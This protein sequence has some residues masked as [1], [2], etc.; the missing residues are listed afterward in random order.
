MPETR[1]DLQLPLVLRK[2]IHQLAARYNKWILAFAL[3]LC[4]SPLLLIALAALADAEYGQKLW[5]ELAA[6]W[7]WWLFLALLPVAVVFVWVTIRHERLTVTSMGLEYRSP[8]RGPLAFLRSLR[9][10][11]R[12]SWTEVQSAILRK[13]MPIPRT[14]ARRRRLVMKMRHGETR[15]L[16]PYAWYTVPDSAGL[17][18]REAINLKDERYL[19]AVHASPL[20]R[21]VAD[22]GLLEDAPEA[23]EESGDAGP[24]ADLPG[25]SFDMTSQPGMM[26]VLGGLVLTGGYAV[27]D[28]LFLSPW[29]YLEMPPVGPFLAAGVL[30][31]IVAMVVT[32]SAPI[33]E[34]STLAAL[35]ALAAAGAAYPGLLRVNAATDADGVSGYRYRQVAAGRFESVDHPG[36]PELVFSQGR[37][38]WEQFP[39]DAEREF[40]LARGE[41]AF[42]QL[43]LDEVRA[44]QRRFYRERRAARDDG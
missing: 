2:R 27:V 42:W 9:P 13:G 20:F 37:E 7:R 10:D 17:T 16:E 38:F 12:L 22:Q 43:D 28:G 21:I 15:S 6:D 3:L 5:E 18:F 44:A 8:L 30:A 1:Q 33:L 40:T 19:E 11:W 41:F 14:H 4:V 24:L 39:P 25:G 29:R 34:R 23:E 35:F 36:M 31:L 26:A 32:R